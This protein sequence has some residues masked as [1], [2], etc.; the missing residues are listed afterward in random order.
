MGNRKPAPLSAV[1]QAGLDHD[2]NTK[3]Q[4]V[5]RGHDTQ[6]LLH[7]EHGIKYLGRASKEYKL[8][9]RRL[10]GNPSDWDTTRA[11]ALQWCHH[12]KLC[13]LDA[14]RKAK[15]LACC[16]CIEVDKLK[17]LHMTVPSVSKQE[18]IM[19]W[20]DGRL[21]PHEWVYEVHMIPGWSGLIDLAI[22]S[23]GLGVQIDGEQH[24]K[25]SMHGH[26]SDSQLLLDVRCNGLAWQARAKLLRLHFDDLLSKGKALI[27][28]AK[29]YAHAHADTPLLV[30]S[31][32][33]R[34]VIVRTLSG[35]TIVET[36]YVAYMQQQ[37]SSMGQPCKVN[38][39]QDGSIWLTRY[40]FLGS[41]CSS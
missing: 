13:T 5:T 41:G 17:Q 23:C 29:A 40:D 28:A 8:L 14:V 36:P 37:L 18:P 24:F 19:H 11:D 20:L 9:F 22:L 27:G 1:Q 15:D 33:F 6:Y 12:V 31:Y 10:A 7:T 39:Q 34:K 26:N 25:D 4:K 16:L 30:L 2:H 32:S 3:L 35:N 21:R 38:Q